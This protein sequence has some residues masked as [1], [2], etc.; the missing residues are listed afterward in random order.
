MGLGGCALGP[1]RWAERLHPPQSVQHGGQ[2]PLLSGGRPGEEGQGVGA[3]GL[4]RWQD[5]E[6]ERNCS[7]PGLLQPPGHSRCS[8][9]PRVGICNTWAGEMGQGLR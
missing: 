4:W 5:P 2:W 6:L 9:G 1:E 3:G 8:S 7:L